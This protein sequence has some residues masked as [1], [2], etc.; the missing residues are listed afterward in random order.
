MSL[1]EYSTIW[2]TDFD[3]STCRHSLVSLW[4]LF[5]WFKAANAHACQLSIVKSCLRESALQGHHG[6]GQE[7]CAW[8][9]ACCT[10]SKGSC[11]VFGQDLSAFDLLQVA[12]ELRI[13]R[14][15]AGS[16][17]SFA[18]DAGGLEA[19]QKI[20]RSSKSLSALNPVWQQILSPCTVRSDMLF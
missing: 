18:T 12:E 7:G 9:D 14:D 8:K 19:G 16:G 20:E 4:H 3:A 6:A 13:E 17:A 11:A 2:I 5:F 1:R 10:T 15:S